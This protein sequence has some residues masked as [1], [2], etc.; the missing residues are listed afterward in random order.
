MVQTRHQ[1]QQ[2]SNNELDNL[3]TDLH[4]NDDGLT[5]AADEEVNIQSSSESSTATE[6]DINEQI[7][8]VEREQDQLL[9]EHQLETLQ[10]EVQHLHQSEAEET[11]VQHPLAGPSRPVL[12]K[13]FYQPSF[14]ESTGTAPAIHSLKQLI[15]PQKLAK[16]YG[17]SIHEHID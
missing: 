17:K 7:Q 4:L 8:G 9:K 10:E 12:V 1:S 5:V 6:A 11:L 13:Q 16:Y 14:T 15:Q 3:M 2:I